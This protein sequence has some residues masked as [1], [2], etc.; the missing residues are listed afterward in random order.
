MDDATIAVYQNRADAWKDQR[1]VKRA[2]AATRLAKG[3]VRDVGPVVDLGCGPGWQL[4]QL[5]PGAVGLDATA[6]MLDV[7]RHTGHRALVRADLEALPF[8]TG[9]LGGAWAS[10]SY[11]H[12]ERDRVP[13][14]LADLH[15]SLAVGAPVDLSVF[16]GDSDLRTYP[17]D[18]FAGR[19]FTAWTAQ[20]L[21]DVVAGAGFADVTVVAED[22][23]LV[24]TGVRARTLPDFVG[25]GLRLLTCGLN[26]SLHA[27]DAGY[28]YAGPSNRFW[29]ALDAAGLVSTP[30]QPR[31]MVTVDR[32]GMTCLV[33]RATPRA[34]EL[35]VAEYRAGAARVERLVRWLEPGAVAFVGLAGYRAAI[36]RTA[37]AGLQPEPFGGRPA[38]VLPSTSGLNAATSLAALAEHFRAAASAADT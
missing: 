6:A 12:V 38:Y 35:A 34:D 3:A 29:K 18:D 8:R 17:D 2:D 25:R 27:A 31:R 4:P 20:Q 9:S 7:A 16:V 32:V 10:R 22:N 1:E 36:D 28:G 24:A 13:L 26:P 19:R 30:R 23:L 15:R 33:K 14:A 11:I 21:A 5:G 37:K